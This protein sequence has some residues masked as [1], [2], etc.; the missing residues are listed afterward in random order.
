MV[1]DEQFSDKDFDPLFS[2]KEKKKSNSA[3]ISSLSFTKILLK[4]LFINFKSKY[5]SLQKLFN[6][7][8]RKLYC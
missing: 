5:R 8:L 1:A 6:L 2:E 3:K 4:L 7:F